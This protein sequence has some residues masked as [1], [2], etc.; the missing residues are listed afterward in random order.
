M[1]K[2]NDLGL[3]EALEMPVF[4]CKLDGGFIGFQAGIAEEATA[5]AAFFAELGGNLFLQV[6]A[7]IVRD[8]NQLGH[9]LLKRR[10]QSGMIVPHCINGDSRKAV[11]I[12][13]ALRVGEPYALPF[14]ET[15][16]K[17]RKIGSRCD[18]DIFTGPSEREVLGLT[19]SQQSAV[20]LQGAPF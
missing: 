3:V 19:N 9:L 12:D 11:K 1:V 5:Q 4:A 13:V 8:M 16:G 17:R 7:E 2:H 18:F 6:N 15:H 14:L 10:Y 20:R